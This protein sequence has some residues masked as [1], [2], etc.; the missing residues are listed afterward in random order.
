MC[1]IEAAE[2]LEHKKLENDALKPDMRRDMR[3]IYIYIYA[4]PSPFFLICA[5]ICAAYIE[6]FSQFS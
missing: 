5:E 1:V 3:R 4:I 6:A 2:A